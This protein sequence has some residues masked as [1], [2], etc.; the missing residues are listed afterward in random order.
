MEFGSV[1]KIR[2]MQISQVAK[3]NNTVPLPVDCFLTHFVWRCT[4]MPLM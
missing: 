2:N 3:F 1:A 4:N